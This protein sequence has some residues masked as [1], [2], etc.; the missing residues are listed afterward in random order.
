VKKAKLDSKTATPIEA[1]DEATLLE[2]EDEDEDEESF[3][4]EERALLLAGFES[5]SEDGVDDEDGIEITKLPAPP[6][7]KKALQ[8]RTSQSSGEPGVVYIG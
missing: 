3:T 4:A 1:V 8:N 5:E 2:D 6:K 7:P